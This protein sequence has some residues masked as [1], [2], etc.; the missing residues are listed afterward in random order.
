MTE[1]QDHV[2]VE[3]LAAYAAGDLDATASVA[4]E[5]H[6]LLCPD[7]R[8][9]VEAVTA[10]TGALRSLDPVPMPADVA[11][12]VDAALAAEARPAPATAPSATVL[13]M[14]RRRGPSL[15]GI[16]AVAAGVALI[17]G[18]AVPLVTHGGGDKADST[19]ANAAHEK[20]GPAGTRRFASGL[21]YTH[22]TLAQTLTRALT[23]ATAPPVSAESVQ[24]PAAAGGTTLPTT[25]P[26]SGQQAETGKYVYDAAAPAAVLADDPGRLA[27]CITAL[28]D[29][30]P[31]EGR[32]PLIVDVARYAGKPA[33]VLAFPTV[34][35]GRVTTDRIDVFVAG[36]K[37]G[38]E[39]G[40]DVL[41]FA[42][43]PRPAG[44]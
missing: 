6:V 43:I 31:V 42:R 36:P 7:C 8:A 25:A 44:I 26:P 3:D 2:P 15:A 18:I 29:G 30:A 16:A 38:T 32:T 41:E 40:G 5:A 35:K 1:P 9:D 33:L 19:A 13:P 12:R 21:N 17:G 14:K 24:V 34:S 10:A 39:P 37:C 22:A 27:A 11:A 28:A 23:G 4:V 20:S